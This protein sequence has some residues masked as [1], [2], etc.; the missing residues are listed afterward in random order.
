MM[1]AMRLVLGVVAALYILGGWA[2]G[3]EPPPAKAAAP[4]F[5][6]WP[7]VGGHF[8]LALPIVATGT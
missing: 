1:R 7:R 6:Q 8:G 5:P 3:E 2:R 4:A